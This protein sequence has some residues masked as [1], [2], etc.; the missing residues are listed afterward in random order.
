MDKGG[1]E[2]NG[3][4]CCRVGYGGQNFGGKGGSGLVM[5]R[6]VDG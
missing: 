1:R 2:V 4:R 5:E 3:R 6:I